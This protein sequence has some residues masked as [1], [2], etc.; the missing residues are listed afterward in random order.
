MYAHSVINRIQSTYD[1]M[2]YIPANAAQIHALPSSLS[3]L[4]VHF[5]PNLQHIRRRKQDLIY[6]YRII[7][8]PSTP[9]TARQLALSPR[10]D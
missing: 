8:T 4:F 7:S 5:E 3:P 9:R 10:S 1:E 6:L 2:I